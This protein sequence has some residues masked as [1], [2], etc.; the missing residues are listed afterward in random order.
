MRSLQDQ[1]GRRFCFGRIS[2]NPSRFLRPEYPF[3]IHFQSDG[4]GATEFLRIC[5]IRGIPSKLGFGFLAVFDIVTDADPTEQRSIVRSERLGATEKPAVSAVR[6]AHAKSHFTGLAR[7][8]A[9]RPHF[10]RVVVVVRMQH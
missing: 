1:I 5:Q 10:A 9:G 7:L 2:I 3:R 8:Q 6:V 4:T